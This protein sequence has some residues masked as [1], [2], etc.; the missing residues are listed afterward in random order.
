MPRKTDRQTD[1]GLVYVNF[2][3]VFKTKAGH[4]PPPHLEAQID[5]HPF[6]PVQTAF[7]HFIIGASGLNPVVKEIQTVLSGIGKRWVMAVFLT[8]DWIRDP[9]STL[10]GRAQYRTPNP[11]HPHPPS[12]P[13]PS[14]HELSKNFLFSWVFFS[15][16]SCRLFL[17]YFA[18][19]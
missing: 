16:F 6:R 10:R 14:P 19:K 4:Q 9:Q 5:L 8:F 12:P 11:C 3:K 13:P 15:V 17:A 7:I 2:F 18:L 1:K